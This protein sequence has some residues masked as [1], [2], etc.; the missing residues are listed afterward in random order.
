ME[1]KRFEEFKS[2]LSAP[3]PP[4]VRAPE[5]LMDADGDLKIYY[6]PFEYINEDARLV[7][8][9]ITPG[10][11]QMVNANNEARRALLEGSSDSEAIRLANISAGFS[12]EPMR[13]NLIAQLHHWGF[14]EWLGL[15][16]AN[17][18]FSTSRHLVQTT[19]LLRYPVFF[20]NEDYRGAPDM[21]KNPLLRRY[22]LENFVAEVIKLKNAVFVGLGPQVQKVLHRLVQERLLTSERVIGGMLHPSGNCT[23]RINYLVGDRSGPIPH[24]TALESYDQGRYAFRERML[25]KNESRT[26]FTPKSNL[27]DLVPLRPNSQESD[28]LTTRGLISSKLSF[29]LHNGI[30]VFPHQM[31]R[32]DTGQVAFRISAGGNTLADSEDV[33]E[34]TMIRKVLREGFSVRCRSL[35]GKTTGL[36]KPGYRSVREV[37]HTA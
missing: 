15:D 20:R 7:L 22:L 32:R 8:V 16:S 23:Y 14:H 13:S 19:S 37:L 25:I 2:A 30:R 17:E 26:S 31:K 35:D 34:E 27:I 11:T 21:M 24:A 29:V 28:M 9:G 1:T 10:P 12:G 3:K 6:A 18:L 4:V 33:D 5:L 36:Y